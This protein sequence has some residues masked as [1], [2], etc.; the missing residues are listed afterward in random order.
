MAHSRG[1][2]RR[3]R[4]AQEERREAKPIKVDT[5]KM[6][7]HQLEDAQQAEVTREKLLEQGGF[8]F[9]MP[10]GKRTK[11]VTVQLG[12][13]QSEKLAGAE[14]KSGVAEGPSPYVDVVGSVGHE[15][16]SALSDSVDGTPVSRF[17]VDMADAP[18]TLKEAVQDRY[19]YLLD[20]QRELAAGPNQGELL[21]HEQRTLDSLQPIVEAMNSSEGLPG[22]FDE[23]PT[24]ISEM[25]GSSY[26]QSRLE[27]QPDAGDA[28]V[29]DAYK[30][31]GWINLGRSG[32][33]DYQERKRRLD[34]SAEGE[35][36]EAA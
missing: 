4:R 31:K 15:F 36:S 23:V 12:M 17:R 19:T 9:D 24:Q 21:P 14:Y 27:G 18:D 29:M 1:R 33:R 13:A 30:E 6:T 7:R 25:Q 16:Q 8:T 28:A 26:D 10:D 5:V 35:E 20:R 22:G 34:E 2:A 3:A 11:E 32:R